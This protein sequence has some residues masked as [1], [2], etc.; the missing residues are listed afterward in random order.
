M[1][2]RPT[3]AVSTVVRVSQRTTDERKT[4][5]GAEQT[6]ALA[7][8][9]IRVLDGAQR[10]RFDEKSAQ[11]VARF[12]SR[13]GVKL[14]AGDVRALGRYAR[15]NFE[16]LVALLR[17]RDARVR[18]L[19]I[20]ALGASGDPRAAEPLVR[21]LCA[22]RDFFDHDYVYD[23]ARQLGRRGVPEFERLALHE[24]GARRDGA[25]ESIGM[26]RG[27]ARALAALKRVVDRHGFS[28]GAF[29]ALENL[30]AAGGVA[31]A[32]RGVES[33]DDSTLLDALAAA[34]ACAEAARTA[35][36]HTRDLTRLASAVESRLADERLWSRDGDPW[37]SGFAFAL[38]V[39]LEAAPLRLAAW[40]DDRRWR[41]VDVERRSMRRTLRAKCRTGSR[42]S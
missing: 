17:R 39:L 7:T 33:A 15:A 40:L 30:H 27:G 38:D 37:I 34:A 21:V 25:L 1:A 29:N 20:V 26:S 24:R 42:R 11:F 31:L 19:A 16:N 3:H 12:E 6:A 10:R 2:S 18:Q 22:G 28:P 8:T 35:G 36:T 9:I 5:N 41:G 32:A 4:A 23:A 14:G 13:T